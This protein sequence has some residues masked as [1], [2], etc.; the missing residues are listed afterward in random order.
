MSANVKEA[1]S[2]PDICEQLPPLNQGLKAFGKWWVDCTYTG[3]RMERLPCE[4][5]CTEDAGLDQATEAFK[6]CMQ[7]C[8][9]VKRFA[10]THRKL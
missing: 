4:R 3:T 9:D 1:R 2:N 10:E 6:R 7:T 8:A 5:Y